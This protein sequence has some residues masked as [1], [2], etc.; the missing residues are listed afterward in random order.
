MWDF[1]FLS[2]LFLLLC[3]PGNGSTNVKPSTRVLTKDYILPIYFAYL[4]G[5]SCTFYVC[6]LIIVS[7]YFQTSNH[8]IENVPNLCLCFVNDY[9]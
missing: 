4:E 9:R 3:W 2:S 1:Y 8:R 5:I 6:R 7:R